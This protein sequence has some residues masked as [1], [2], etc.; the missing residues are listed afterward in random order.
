VEEEELK[1]GAIDVAP[2]EAANIVAH[3]KNNKRRS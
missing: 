1:D 3:L 2:A